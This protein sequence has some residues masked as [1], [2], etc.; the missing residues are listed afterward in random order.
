MR[1]RHALRHGA[2]HAAQ[3]LGRARLDQS[4]CRALDVRAR[5]ASART[6]RLHEMEI[7]LEL[8]GERADRRQHLQG[9]A[10]RGLGGRLRAARLGF[11]AVELAHDRAGF[12]ALAFGEFD[13]RRADLHQIALG[14]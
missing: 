4:F 3:R 7:D 6:R 2:T 13:E 12:L 8:A 9:A 5:D 1:L 14:A 10:A 11:G